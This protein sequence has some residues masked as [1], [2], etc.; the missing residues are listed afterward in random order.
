MKNAATEWSYDVIST[1]SYVIIM[2][3]ACE[4]VTPRLRTSIRIVAIMKTTGK[5]LNCSQSAHSAE[6]C[7]L[8]AKNIYTG[9]QYDFNKLPPLHTCGI[10]EPNHNG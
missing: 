1:S 9:Y 4:H 6:F 2:L 10:V 8:L 5:H 3:E 7:S